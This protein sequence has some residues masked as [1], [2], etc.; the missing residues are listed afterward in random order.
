MPETPVDKDD[1]ASA[2]KDQVRATGKALI[3]EAEAESH[4]VN[5]ATH[6][7]LRFGVLA[8]NPAHTL[9]ALLGCKSVGH[10][11]QSTVG[12]PFTCN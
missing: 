1:L 3:M 8:P 6:R 9:G 12:P 2:A 11:F 5:E 7:H 4:R 10:L